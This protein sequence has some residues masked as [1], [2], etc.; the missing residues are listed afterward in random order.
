ML[1]KYLLTC[2]LFCICS[3]KEF[4]RHLVFVNQTIFPFHKCSTTTL[5]FMTAAANMST[6]FSGSN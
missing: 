4:T 2:Q 1:V 3:K 6:S 5:P